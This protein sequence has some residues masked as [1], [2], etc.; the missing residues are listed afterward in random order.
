[1]S[2][3][4]PTCQPLADQLARLREELAGATIPPDGTP[5]Q[6][7]AAKQR[8][9][10]LKDQIQR[11]SGQLQVCILNP[12]PPKPPGPPHPSLFIVEIEPVQC[13]Q[14]PAGGGPAQLRVPLVAGKRTAVRVY[15]D[16]MVTP[17]GHDEGAGPDR[18]PNVTG[19]L[20][21]IDPI[22]GATVAS[23]VA[24]LNPGGK[25]IAG[26][27]GG[28]PDRN[29]SSTSLNFE[30]PLAAILLPAVTITARV[31]VEGHENEPGG[32]TTSRSQ[33]FSFQTR[34]TQ[35]VTPFLIGDGKAGLAPPSLSTFTAAL[36]QGALPRY[37][38]SQL[39]FL[40][41]QG[42]SFTTGEDLRNILGWWRLLGQVNTVILL[43]G[44]PGGIRAGVVPPS[45]GYPVG[46]V[47]FPRVGFFSAPG[48][49]V[50]VAD[51]PGFAHE[52]GHTFGIDHARC[53]GTE[54]WPVDGRLPPDGHTD[55]VGM[56]VASGTPFPMGTQGT[57]IPRGTSEVMGYCLDGFRWPSTVFY[58]IVFTS[59]PI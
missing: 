38:M 56:D 9:N 57:V 28:S 48:F 7:A 11:V 19:Q 40:V 30:L 26:N 16:P 27:G 36:L 45:A 12:P 4:P 2:V 58:S 52:M 42:F 5:G 34:S 39:G 8:I 31:W 53:N 15:V 29:D 18:W 49:V 3:I 21:V 43:S 14:G 37:P 10:S 23:G 54:P 35:I 32:W 41:T 6:K 33:T 25:I 51:T 59:P 47:G 44:P 24:P 46:G 1:M 20:R 55:E 50:N 13:L 17:A 22:T